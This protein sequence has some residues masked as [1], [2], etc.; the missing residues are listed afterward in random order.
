MFRALLSGS[1]VGLVVLVLNMGSEE[2][3]VGMR[4]SW[5]WVAIGPREGVRG[6]TALM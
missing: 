2:L 5:C 1:A 6:Q 4:G 3:F